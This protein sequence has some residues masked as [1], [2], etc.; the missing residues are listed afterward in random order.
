MKRG[1]ERLCF[2]E[3]QTGEALLSELER[4]ANPVSTLGKIHSLCCDNASLF[5]NELLGSNRG[6]F[7]KDLK[8]IALGDTE[9]SRKLKQDEWA[10]C[11]RLTKDIVLGIS[12]YGEA[13]GI[14]GDVA[15]DLGDFVRF[16]F[17]RTPKT[18]PEGMDEITS[19]LASALFA[20]NSTYYLY[21]ILFMGSFL[22]LFFHLQ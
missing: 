11:M 17:D 19:L 7:L 10:K 8:Q 18:V 1:I 9:K 20:F 2:E 12:A 15:L 5:A 4:A 22:Y 3:N 13:S 14:P 6:R 16:I 21:S